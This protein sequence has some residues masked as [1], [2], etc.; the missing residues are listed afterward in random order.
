M[1]T[2]AELGIFIAD[3]RTSFRPGETLSVSALWALPE[4]PAALEARLFW[5]TR[6]KG[7]DDVG[8]VAA[9]TIENPEAAGERA[10]SFKLPPQP[11]SFSGKLISLIWAVE[12]V[13]EPGGRSARA[14]FVLSPDGTEILLNAAG[15][16]GGA[17]AKSG[18]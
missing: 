12:L 17:S 14:E 8:V 16:D 11:W 15:A 9:R 18:G 13:A 2:D 4:K 1:S 10:I 3:G 6:G 5:Y 7:T